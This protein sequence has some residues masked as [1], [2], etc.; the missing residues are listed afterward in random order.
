MPAIFTRLRRAARIQAR[1]LTNEV[2]KRAPERSR[3][4]QYGPY[5]F[6]YPSRSIVGRA[7]AGGL[8]WDPHLTRLVA[9]LPPSALVCEVGSNIGA[10][11]LTMVCAR[12]DLRFVCFEPS[13]RFLPYLRENVETNGLGGRVTVEPRL[14]GPDGE[15]WLLTSNT[16]T[17]S[18]VPGR[19]D[20]HIPLDSQDLTSVGLDGYFA[21]LGETPAFLKVDTDGFDH[22]VLE[23][24]RGLLADARPTLA[25]EYTPAL[26]TRA[27]SSPDA[28]RELLL[29]CGYRTAD[30]YGGDGGLRR[31]R[32]PLGDPIQT[33]SYLDLVVH[34]APHEG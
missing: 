32:H 33:D 20:G 27:G 6:R 18:V 15:Q 17:G 2:V 34:G 11:L 30:L 26:L 24:A 29:A 8:T 5:A 23:S 9:G 28:L 12:P 10:S 4:T 13:L 3:L 1:A 22:K 19:Y 31:E 14:V 16:S 21:A 25:V 7:V